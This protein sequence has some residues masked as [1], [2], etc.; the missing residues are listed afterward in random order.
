MIPE[1]LQNI[2]LILHYEYVLLSQGALSPHV[3]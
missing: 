1:K 3:E 2:L